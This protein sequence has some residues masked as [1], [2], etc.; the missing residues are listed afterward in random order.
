[1]Y[2][3][4]MLVLVGSGKGSQLQATGSKSTR[5]QAGQLCY[6]FRGLPARDTMSTFC[7][8]SLAM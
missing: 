2:D 6:N 8:H 3:P 5:K 7:R 1:M 4:Q